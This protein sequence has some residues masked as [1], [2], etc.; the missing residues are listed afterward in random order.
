MLPYLSASR[1]KDEFFSKLSGGMLFE[2][3]RV[4][5]SPL[6]VREIAKQYGLNI[7]FCTEETVAYKKYGN[8]VFKVDSKISLNE[9]I[10]DPIDQ[11]EVIAD[12]KPWKKITK[13]QVAEITRGGDERII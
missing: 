13:Q 7:T 10:L 1:D 4:A 3:S 8:S 9:R 6:E 12:N 2:F 5:Y 11:N